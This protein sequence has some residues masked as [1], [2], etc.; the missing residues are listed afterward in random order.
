MDSILSLC[1]LNMFNVPHIYSRVEVL[2][3]DPGGG[4]DEDIEEGGSQR[5][6]ILIGSSTD[7]F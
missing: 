3:E 4:D 5:F 2:D 7:V 6:V 1:Y